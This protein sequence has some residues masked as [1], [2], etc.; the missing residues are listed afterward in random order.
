[1]A[2]IRFLYTTGRAISEDFSPFSLMPDG[3]HGAKK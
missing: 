1:M 3:G 2:A